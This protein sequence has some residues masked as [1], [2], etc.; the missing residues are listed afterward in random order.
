[1]P[2]VKG[3]E[4]MFYPIKPFVQV[5]GIQRGDFGIHADANVPGSAGCIVL[6][7]K[8]NGW[9]VFPERM[10][11]IAAAGLFRIPLPVVYC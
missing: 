9:K 1:M 6:P 2:G 5:N 4:G 10:T 3:I 11:E 8:G 7:P